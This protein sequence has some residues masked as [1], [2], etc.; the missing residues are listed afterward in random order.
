MVR[1]HIPDPPSTKL[2]EDWVNL[3]PN[4][5]LSAWKKKIRG[6]LDW[7]ALKALSNRK[8]DRY[9]SAAALADDLR[10][11]LSDEIVLA[12]RPTFTYQARKFIKRNRIATITFSLISLD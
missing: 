2:N 7:I 11:V 9:E 12:R 6:D 3:P 8:E 1:E 10:R 5:T 4:Q